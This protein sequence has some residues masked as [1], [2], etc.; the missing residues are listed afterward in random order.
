MTSVWRAVAIVLGW[1]SPRQATS[2]V[3]VLGRLD[4][5]RGRS[6]LGG[7]TTRVASGDSRRAWPDRR[8]AEVRR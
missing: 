5:V 6:P 4:A 3:E 8:T 1:H 2:Q 7:S